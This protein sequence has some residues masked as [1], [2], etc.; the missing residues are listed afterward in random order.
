MRKQKKMQEYLQGSSTVYSVVKVD[1]DPSSHLVERAF[2]MWED[3]WGQQPSGPWKEYFLGRKPPKSSRKRRKTVVT[4]VTFC[5]G[6]RKD[7]IED[8]FF[9]WLFLWLGWCWYVF[10][11]NSLSCV[12]F[13]VLAHWK[14]SFNLCCIV[15]GGHI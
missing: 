10:L 14:R 9:P 3:W 7:R 2:Y 12:A 4:E 13:R 15:R 11:S 5:Y 1:E 6:C 8:S